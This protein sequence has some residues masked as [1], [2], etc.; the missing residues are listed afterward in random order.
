MTKYEKEIVSTGCVKRIITYMQKY[1]PN[2][3]DVLIMIM[4][5]AYCITRFCIRE[6]IPG[7]KKNSR[8]TSRLTHEAFISY[9]DWMEGKSPELASRWEFKDDA[10]DGQ[11]AFQ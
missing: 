9:L 8:K 10:A 1:N 7:C 5:A 11:G 4:N 3:S 6:G 2:Y